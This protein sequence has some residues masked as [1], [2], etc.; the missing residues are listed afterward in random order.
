MN[1]LYRYT[2]GGD[3]YSREVRLDF[4][5][6]LNPL[7]I[8]DSVRL[9]AAN[10]D[11]THYPDPYCTALREKL[12]QY[13]G[14]PENRIVCGNGAADLIYRLVRAASP[15]RAL[16][17]SPTFSEYEKALAELNCE[18]V[19]HALSE[20]NGF[21]LTEDY[22]GKITPETDMLFLCSPNNPVG[23]VIPSDLLERII[24]KCNETGTMAV[25]DE[26]FL[27][28]A[29]TKFS[30]SAKSIMSENIVIVKAFT[31]SCCMAGLRLGYGLFG[32][33][34]LA[35]DVLSCGQ[36]WSVSSP[37]Q[38]AGIA[39]AETVFATDFME[40]TRQLVAQ[41]RQYLSECLAEFGF[42]VY[43]SAANYI[44]F[45]GYPLLSEKLLERKIAIRRCD[46]Y[47]GLGEEYFRIAVRTHEENEQLIKAIK[48]IKAI[49]TI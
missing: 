35:A 27:D 9:A 11:F 47:H 17:V 19:L 12:S 23:N 46:D 13:E 37:A 41:E 32:S 39:A 36:P 7:G 22:L 15:K 31:K 1:G 30:Y 49:K 42:K 28:F 21:A 43:P 10:A 20:E 6:N 8:P 38:A 24:S 16:L 18:I 40:I 29:D 14:V 3:I 25:I 33:E 45:K 5:A 2:H 44:L 48:A 26:C 4:S 34:R